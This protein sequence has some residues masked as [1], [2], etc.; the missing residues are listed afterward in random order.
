M[1]DRKV[2]TMN[3]TGFLAY[4]SHVMLLNLP[5]SYRQCL[6]KPC[7]KQAEVILVDMMHS[8]LL[9]FVVMV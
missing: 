9:I 8:I 2:T 5:Y 1:T 7:L 3:A 4:H 6:L